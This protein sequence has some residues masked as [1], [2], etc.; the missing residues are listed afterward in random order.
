MIENGKRIKIHY[1]L[2]VDSR[3]IDSTDSRDPFEFVQGNDEIIPAL[4]R[5]LEGLKMG[6]ECEVVVGPDDA[7][8]VEDP[9]AY[10]EV[11]KSR[12]PEGEFEIGM[13]LEV[14]SP[15]GRR[16]PAT[17]SEVRPESVILNFNHPLAGK[18]LH[19]KIL[20]VDVR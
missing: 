1:T 4:Q 2:T 10:M 15:D 7:Y 20:I 11:E 19:F 13:T 5:R 18:E 12:L 9:N 3:V 17:I 6:D 16:V 8:G 14:I